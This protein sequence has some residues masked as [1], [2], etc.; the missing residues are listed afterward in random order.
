M[1]RP[2]IAIGLCSLALAEAPAFA[3]SEPLPQETAAPVASPKPA[4]PSKPAS[5]RHVGLHFG[6]APSVML[7]GEWRYLYAFANASLA[8]PTSIGAIAFS[9][10]L[11]ASFPFTPKKSWRFDVFAY[12]APLKYLKPY[13]A[14][15]VG[16]GLGV[17]IHCTFDSGFTLGFKVPIAGYAVGPGLRGDAGVA[18]FYYSSAL[19]LPLFDFGYRF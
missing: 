4:D 12:A 2:W 9:G 13:D 10:G 18:A 3:D 8:F 11:G 7:D 17:G 19:G 15:A 6:A 5:A 14:P 16:L 1:R